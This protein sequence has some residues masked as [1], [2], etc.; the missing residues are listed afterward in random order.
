MSVPEATAAEMTDQEPGPAAQKRGLEEVGA[1][2]AAGSAHLEGGDMTR[3]YV[4]ALS[5]DALECLAKIANE[6]DEPDYN[7]VDGHIS[8]QTR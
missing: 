8:L 6:M 3:R 1:S 7:I 4:E 2:P 5:V